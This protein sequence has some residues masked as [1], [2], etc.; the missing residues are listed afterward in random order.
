MKSISS[1]RRVSMSI[2]T[3]LFIAIAIAFL[4][5]SVDRCGMFDAEAWR[6]VG[7]NS[8]LLVIGLTGVLGRISRALIGSVLATAVIAFAGLMAFVF[9]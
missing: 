6:Y 9:R 4:K 8:I 7:V 2:L 5:R 1:I 3:L